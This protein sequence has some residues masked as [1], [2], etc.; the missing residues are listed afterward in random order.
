MGTLLTVWGGEKE[1]GFLTGVSLFCESFF[2]KQPL[3]WI[4]I[5]FVQGVYYVLDFT[6]HPALSMLYKKMEIELTNL[7]GKGRDSSIISCEL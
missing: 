6:S 7:G 3:Y 1:G 2:P 4:Q 5:K